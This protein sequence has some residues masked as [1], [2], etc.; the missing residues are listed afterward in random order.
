MSQV[1]ASPPT[2]HAP[3]RMPSPLHNSC[4]MGK[5]AASTEVRCH[6]GGPEKQM[7]DLGVVCAELSG[8]VTDTCDGTCRAYWDANYTKCLGPFWQFIPAPFRPPYDHVKEACSA[9]TGESAAGALILI[10]SV[11]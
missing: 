11:A 3:Y 7:M 2:E 1:L 6:P 5:C 10:V 8:G 9:V 4:C